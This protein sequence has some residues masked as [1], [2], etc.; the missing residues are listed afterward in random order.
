METEHPEPVA[1]LIRSGHNKVLDFEEQKIAE[2]NRTIAR[3]D[4]SWEIIEGLFKNLLPVEIRG[5]FSI[6]R[7]EVFQKI[8]DAGRNAYGFNQDDIDLLK[9]YIP[10]T[11]VIGKRGV[12]SI[13]GLSDIIVTVNEEAGRP[14]VLF[15]SR[16]NFP[17]SAEQDGSLEVAIYFASQ[18]L[19]AEVQPFVLPDAD[20]TLDLDPSEP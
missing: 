19:S 18:K 4:E 1:K 2:W 14:V 7:S 10:E 15:D 9:T 6:L 12:I 13:P 5:Y 3:I 11:S 20:E 16:E 17:N 8:E